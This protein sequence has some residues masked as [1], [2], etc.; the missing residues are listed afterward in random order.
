MSLLTFVSPHSR[1]ER[2]RGKSVGEGVDAVEND[3]TC[4]KAH[5]SQMRSSGM[6][7][8]SPM[9]SIFLF[10]PH[11]SLLYLLL[12]QILRSPT[13]RQRKM[14]PLAVLSS[15]QSSLQ[16]IK[17][18][19]T[20]RWAQATSCR[21]MEVPSLR[22]CNAIGSIAQCSRWDWVSWVDREVAELHFGRC[23]PLLAKTR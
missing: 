7:P 12:S 1:E 22:V 4:V 9:P 16:P 8:C 10:N 5:V 23:R 15:R 11:I 20:H 14:E 17:A 13:Y 18:S 21:T 6:L 3:E 2:T 19:P